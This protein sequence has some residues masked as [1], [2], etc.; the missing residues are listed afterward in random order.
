MEENKEN[1]YEL[2]RNL[3]S[4]L[5]LQD[6]CNNIKQPFDL[7]IDKVVFE[8]DYLGAKWDGND[9]VGNPLTVGQ[10]LYFIKAF[11][12]DETDL[13]TTGSVLLRR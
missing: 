3:V 7:L 11:G 4:F 9:A 1:L 12:K 13:S 8:A 10:Y 6:E 2:F 5:S